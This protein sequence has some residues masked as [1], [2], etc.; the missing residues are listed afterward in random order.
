LLLPGNTAKFPSV[1]PEHGGRLE[2]KLTQASPTTARYAL[3]IFSPRGD[4]TTEVSL[5]CDTGKLDIAE[6][7]GTPPAAWLDTFARALLKTVVRNKSGDS[8]W[9]R[10]ITRWRPEPRP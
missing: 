10:R 3:S 4:A 6:W 1:R 2:L 9:P 5:D 8:E 7:R